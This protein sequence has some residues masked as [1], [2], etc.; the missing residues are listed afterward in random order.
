LLPLNTNSYFT[1]YNSNVSP[2]ITGEFA[3]SAYRMGHSLMRQTLSMSNIYQNF[4]QNNGGGPGTGPNQFFPP[5]QLYQSFFQSDL[6]YNNN[7]EGL[8]GVL[9]GILNDPAWQFGTYSTGLQ[10]NLFQTTYPNGTTYAID[11]LAFKI[12]R[13]RDKQ[14]FNITINSFSDLI[15]LKFMNQ[16][17]LQ[18]L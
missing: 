14:C 16:Q 7:T 1:G 10:N 3:T 17:S 11:L 12:N 9:L 6:A 4:I 18:Q 5:Y 8:N 15:R 2:Q 13:G